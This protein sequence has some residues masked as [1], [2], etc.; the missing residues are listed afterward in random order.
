MTFLIAATALFDKKFEVVRRSIENQMPGSNIVR[1]APKGETDG[2]KY[3]PNLALERFKTVLS[4]FDSGEDEVI[5]IGADFYVYDSFDT[6]MEAL[7]ISDVVLTPHII[8]PQQETHKIYQTGIINGDLI[9]F[10]RT[11]NSRKVLKWLISNSY[12]FVDKKE[13]GI[14]FEQNYLSMLPFIFDGIKILRDPRYNIAFY[15][16]HERNKTSVVAFHFTG[17]EKGMHPKLSRHSEIEVGGFFG[18]ILKEYDNK[19]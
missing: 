6:F 12:N 9:G 17:Y 10:R 16:L 14:F 2:K 1:I 4:L 19:I 13:E 5:I 8:Y 7:D 11:S 18:K 3:I 15:N